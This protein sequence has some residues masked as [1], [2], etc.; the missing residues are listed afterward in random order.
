MARP[1]H[2]QR[3]AADLAR[4]SP[5]GNWIAFI[6][7]YDGDEMWDIF[8]VSPQ[9]GD[10]INLTTSRETAEESPSW[11][12]DGKQIAYQ[13]KPKTSPSYEI[14][15]IDVETRRTKH[16]TQNTP[17][18]LGNFHPIFSHDGKQLAWTQSHANGK[19]SNV[20]VADLATG[21]AINLTE[22]TGDVQFSASEWSP[23]NR[24]L[25]IT[26]NAENGY[27]NVGLLDIATKKIDWLTR[28]KWEIEAGGFSP[29]GKTVT[30]TAN[31]DGYSDIYFH[32][33]AI[34][35]TEALPLPK[36]WNGIAGAE[37]AF[38][39]DGS[40]LLYTPQR[41]QL[42]QR[43]L[44]LRRRLTQVA[45]SHACPR[46]RTPQRRH[47]RALARALSQQRRQVDHLRARLRSQQHHP[48]RQVPGDRLHPRRPYLADRQQ[49]QPH[50]PVHGSTRDTSSLRRTIAEA[51]AT[52]RN[53]RKPT[54]KTPAAANCRTLSTLPSSSRDRLRRS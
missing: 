19:D 52:A 11:S 7:D 41:S 53:S 13:K 18:H 32:D 36:G 38:T 43:Y 6:S 46:R 1:A 42:S 50:H 25:L 15:V 12:P 34:K 45:T 40:R 27:D 14:D 20:F 3:S 24:H 37:T 30:W 39:K 26:G 31:V 47:G 10:V 54:A 51:P 4:L 5:D 35:K 22:H 9:N 49:F 16:I 28:D 29:D 23:D 17:A 8:L 2:H 33:L 21:K 48:Q 44:G